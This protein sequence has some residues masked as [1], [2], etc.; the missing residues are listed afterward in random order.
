MKHDDLIYDVGMHRGEDTNFYLKKGFRVV[1]FE[2]DPDLV[3]LNRARFSE[4]A[5]AGRLA[6]VGGAIVEDPGPGMVEF[7][8]SV[9]NSEWG[10]IDAAWAR[11]NEALGTP[12]DRI[13]V[14][15]VDFS[16]CL[17]RYGIPHYLKIDIEGADLVCLRQLS[18][19]EPRP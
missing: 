19:H 4:A 16:A 10:T 11:R 1:A 6:I 17:A 14:D 8:K 2:A 5:R 13:R 15:A 12:S 7:F 9:G 3:A 18:R